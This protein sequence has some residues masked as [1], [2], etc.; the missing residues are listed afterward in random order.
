MLCQQA[1]L[2]GE[3]QRNAPPAIA[4]PEYSRRFNVLVT[5]EPH[6]DCDIMAE[7]YLGEN[8]L[9]RQLV[10]AVGGQKVF[11]QTPFERVDRPNWPIEPEYREVLPIKQCG[12]AA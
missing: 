4:V 2:N 7:G 8:R 6:S 9:R 11:H 10:S 3:R 12:V 5:I 1:G